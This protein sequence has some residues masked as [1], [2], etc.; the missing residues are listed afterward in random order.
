MAEGY[1]ITIPD[2]LSTWIS[3]TLADLDGLVDQ[4]DS[5]L[6]GPFPELVSTAY[7]S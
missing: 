2:T 4:I 1:S 7:G 5:L 3:D 6:E